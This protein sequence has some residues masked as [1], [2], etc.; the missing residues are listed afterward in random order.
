MNS[1]KDFS[2][3]KKGPSPRGPRVLLSIISSKRLILELPEEVVGFF[4][5]MGPFSAMIFA[6]R[7]G[8]MSD[9]YDRPGYGKRTPFILYIS[10]MILLGLLLIPYR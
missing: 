1:F 7:I 10:A 9:D 4:L 2:G 3:R 6:P 5:A 8:A